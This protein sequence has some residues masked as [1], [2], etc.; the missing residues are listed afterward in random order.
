[1]LFAG[2][3]N[4]VG[5]IA[6]VI[7]LL[8]LLYMLFRPSRCGRVRGEREICMGTVVVLAAVV[9]AVVFA[10]RSMVR[11]KK[12]GKSIQCGGDCRNC[13]RGCH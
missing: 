6:A 3:P 1:M 2:S 8:G 10:I 7:V 13:G 5:L 11:D 12:Q 4:A 9:V